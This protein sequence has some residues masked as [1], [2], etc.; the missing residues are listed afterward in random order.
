LIVGGGVSANSHLRERLHQAGA[1]RGVEILFPPKELSIDNAAM[2]AG[3]GGALFKKGYRSNLN[4]T[5]Q[6]NW[7]M[8]LAYSV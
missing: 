8:E 3:L 2:V 1:E 4:F 5:A 6:P 7:N